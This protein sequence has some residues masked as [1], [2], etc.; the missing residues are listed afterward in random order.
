MLSHDNYTY[1]VD[2][3]VSNYVMDR[4]SLVG[5]CRILSY[6]PLSHAAAQIVDLL[7]PLKLGYNVFYPD[8]SVL[9]ANLLKFLNVA[10]PYIYIKKEMPFWEFPE[11][12]KRFSKN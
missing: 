12:G 5:K 9:Q 8:A 3:I 4:P 10:K 7:V 2:Q 6:L 1:I 11:F